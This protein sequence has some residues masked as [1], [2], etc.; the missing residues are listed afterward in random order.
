MCGIFAYTGTKNNAADMVLKGLKLL[1]YRGYDSWGIAS[2]PMNNNTFRIEKHVGKIGSATLRDPHQS[3]LAI[4]HTRWATHG[5][6]T[7]ANAHPHL[8]A[9]KEIAVVH[10]GIIENY[11]ELKAHVLRKGYVF[12]SQTDTEVATYMIADLLKTHTFPEAVSKSFALFSG[13]NAL[14]VINKMSSEVIAIRKGSPLALGR[15]S[16]GLY[17]ASDATAMNEYTRDVYFLEDYDMVVCTPSRAQLFD[18]R[19][20]Q[21]KEIVWEHLDFTVED[22]S[23]GTFDHFMLKEIM[24]QPKVLTAV[25]TILKP[26]IKEYARCLHK[27]VMFVGCGTAY[28]AS[29]AGVYLFSHIARKNSNAVIGS[30][31]GYSLPFVDKNMFVSFISQSGETIDIVEHAQTLKEKRIPYGTIVNRLGSTLERSTENKILLP[32]G[33]EQCVLATKSYTA[34]LGVLF[35]LSHE[36]AGTIEEGRRQLTHV[37]RTLRDILAP[38]Y[39]KKHIVPLAKLLIKH[40]RIF[41]IG[42]GISYPLA[43]EAA[44]KLKEVTY[45]HTEGFAG[46]DLKHGVIALIKKDVPCIVFAPRDETYDSIISNA[47]E[48]KS[49]GGFIIGIS[50]EPNEVFDIHIPTSDEGILSII[51]NIVI[52]QLLAYHMAILLGNDPDKPRN[53]AKSVTVK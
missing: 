26:Q 51:P 4:G 42:R 5:G 33:P 28:H 41:I 29:L 46:G 15:A 30:E 12:V 49:R 25:A 31:L 11:Q 43:L 20:Q 7:I 8:D 24:E 23:K 21:E 38:A 45:I 35:L 48:V 53:L 22:L 50:R 10:N 19:T 2:I 47:M 18:V 52:I 32:A 27:G 40:D 17:V 3:H 37:A 34:K 14:V 1:E 16:D 6:V 13:S 36:V 44:L 9:H 39:V